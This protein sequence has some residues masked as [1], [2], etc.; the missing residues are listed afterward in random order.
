MRWEINGASRGVVHLVRF[1]VADVLDQQIN[2]NFDRFQ[3]A[4]VL[5]LREVALRAIGEGRAPI[6]LARQFQ[7]NLRDAGVAR[8]APG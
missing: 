6:R 3:A 8:P 7:V 4:H 5:R 2:V 1:Q